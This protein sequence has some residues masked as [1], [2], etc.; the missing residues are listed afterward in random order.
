MSETQ[1]PTVTLTPDDL[2]AAYEHGRERDA[3]RGWSRNFGIE[4]EQTHIRGLKAEL[5]VARYYGLEPDLSFRRDGDGGVDFRAKVRNT[6]TALDV[7]ATQYIIDPWLKVRADG[8]HAADAYLLAAVNGA[9]V[10][11][12]GW[13]AAATVRAT[14]PSDATGHHR[15][16]VLRGD[17]LKP[18]PRPD[19]V[20][21]LASADGLSPAEREFLANNPISKEELLATRGGDQRAAATDTSLEG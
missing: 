18:V 19:S 13:A 12:V 20:S 1:Q 17:D 9:V 21:E 16:H 14:E 11:L 6:P 4:R 5:A 3:A 15:N 2:A 7:K 10:R 8:H